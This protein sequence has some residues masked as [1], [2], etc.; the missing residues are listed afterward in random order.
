MASDLKHLYLDGLPLVDVVLEG[1]WGTYEA[2]LA[3][4]GGVVYGLFG[5]LT[6]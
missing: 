6:R 1:L 5:L 2:L 3:A 4:A